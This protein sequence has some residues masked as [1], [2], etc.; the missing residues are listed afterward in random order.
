M[1]R[2]EVWRIHTVGR[3]RTVLV[4]GNDAVTEMYDIVQCVPIEDPEV[5]RET[6][7][8]VPIDEPIKGVAV[9][10]DAG[11]FRKARFVEQIGAVHGAALDRVEVALR[12]VYD[13]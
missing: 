8:T 10:V 6:L 12:A 3:E 5:V 4:V 1:R 13:L 2:G 9:A 7:V 11:A